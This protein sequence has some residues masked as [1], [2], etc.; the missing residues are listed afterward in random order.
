MRILKRITFGPSL[1]VRPLILIS[2]R[3][4][5]LLRPPRLNDTVGQVLTSLPNQLVVVE[6]TD[7]LTMIYLLTLM[8]KHA[9]KSYTKPMMLHYSFRFYC[10]L[11]VFMCSLCSG[12]LR[13]PYV[14]H[15]VLPT[16]L[17][18]HCFRRCLPHKGKCNIIAALCQIT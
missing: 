4:Q 11:K 3:F 18:A 6:T 13:R 8:L 14:L 9:T 5:Q 2:A 15:L 1:L 17:L 7:F 10:F 16:P 12:L